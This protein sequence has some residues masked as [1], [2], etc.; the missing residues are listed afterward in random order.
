MKKYFPIFIAV[1]F[2]TFIGLGQG[3]FK[4]FDLKADAT[5]VEKKITTHYES[6][7]K[8]L[9]LKTTENKK[10]KLKDLKTPI[11]IINFWATWCKPCLIEFPSIVTM[12]KKYNDDQIMVF[13][14]NQDDED[15]MENIK[16]ITKKYKLNFPNVADTDGS[17]LEK[18]MISAIPVSIIYHKGKVIQVSNGAKDFSSEELYEKFDNLLKK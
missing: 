18:F 8:D 9:E 1:S 6:L 5:K 11:V 17:I 13:G 4:L 16:K 7:Y 15:Q 3:M 2:L 12:K 10:V 14:I